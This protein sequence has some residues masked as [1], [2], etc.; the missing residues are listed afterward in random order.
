MEI[1]VD[2]PFWTVRRPA[3]TFRFTLG[4]GEEPETLTDGDVLIEGPGGKRWF[5]VLQT[6][7]L[8]REIMD[9][10]RAAG[11]SLGGAYFWTKGLVIVREP[12]MEGMIRAVEDLYDHYGDLDDILPVITPDE[13]E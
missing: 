12:G 10:E 5:A 2:E 11:D 6:M 13:D 4:V 1:E 7:D 9:R 3:L 8:I